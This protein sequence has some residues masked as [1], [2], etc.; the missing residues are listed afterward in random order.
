[1]VWFWLLQKH[2][3]VFWLF[4]KHTANTISQ[5]FGFD[6]C[7]IFPRHELCGNRACTILMGTTKFACSH[8]SLLM[9]MTA[10]SFFVLL[11]FFR[12]FGSLPFLFISCLYCASFLVL[13]WLLMMM[14]VGFI[15]TIPMI[16]KSK[17]DTKTHHATTPGELETSKLSVRERMCISNFLCDC[18]TCINSK[19]YFIWWPLKISH[20]LFVFVSGSFLG[21]EF[22]FALNLRI[23]IRQMK[24]SR[25]WVVSCGRRRLFIRFPDINSRLHRRNFL[26]EVSTV[27]V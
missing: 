11:S 6:C 22:A 25:G 3:A 19:I 20:N 9:T 24:T 13:M 2:N 7:S 27:V 8:E 5:C 1:M 16:R 23:S 18:K 12:L 10:L 26:C 21:V 15:S 14:E 4:R 17:E